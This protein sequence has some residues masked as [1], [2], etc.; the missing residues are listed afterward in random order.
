WPPSLPLF[1]LV[2]AASPFPLLPVC[3]SPPL[4][5][6][7]RHPAR[8]YGIQIRR[9]G[10][11]SSGSDDKLQRRVRCDAR[12]RRGDDPGMR[13]R[14]RRAGAASAADPQVAG[15]RGEQRMPARGG[16]PA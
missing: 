12:R 11:A 15:P 7:R 9:G 1:Q 14:R 8:S 5:A 2:A 10:A 16:C 4:P 13:S 3:L 6:L